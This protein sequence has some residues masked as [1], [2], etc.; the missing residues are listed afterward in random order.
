MPPPDP[1]DAFDAAQIPGMRDRLAQAYQRFRALET[2]VIAALA[3]GGGIGAYRDRD[4]PLCAASSR[5]APLFHAHG[6]DVLTCPGCGL[7]YTRQVMV[8]TEDSA[9]YAG[10]DLEREAL[11]LRDS[12]PYLEL[13]TAR[14]T[15][16][17]DLLRRTGGATGRLLEIGCGTGTL[18]GVAAARGWHA[19]G[20]EPGHAAA[21]LATARGAR[22]VR[23]WFPSDLPSDEPPFDA[24]VMLD[25][26]EHFA[27]P[28]ALLRGV[29]DVLRPDG[30][31]FIQVPNWDSPLVRLQGAA[32]SVVCPGHWS[33]FT[34]ATLRATLARAR[35]SALH[36]ETAVTELD[37]VAAFPASDLRALVAVLRPGVLWEGLSPE[38]LYRLNLGYKLVGVFAPAGAE[39]K[40]G[41]I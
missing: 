17:L 6:L 1:R 15:Y 19:L 34:P 28:L 18:L 2:G 9:R 24:V 25:V 35:F 8:E 13:E 41:T 22:V 32:S 4:C 29:R 36:V 3:P 26:L 12:G 27:D 30:R 39:W 21:A 37:R 31:L 11:R 7:T 20:I 10:G 5:V 40:G 33:H 16:Y 23:G 14:D 38:A